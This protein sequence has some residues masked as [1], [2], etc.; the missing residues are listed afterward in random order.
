MFR[1]IIVAGVI[2]MWKMLN[3]VLFEVGVNLF[4]VWYRLMLLL[5]YFFLL[6]DVIANPLWQMLKTTEA[7]VIACYILFIG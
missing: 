1:H 5:L 6:A 2:A 3:P 7:D 4:V